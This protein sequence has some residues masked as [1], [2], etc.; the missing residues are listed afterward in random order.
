MELLFIDSF[1]IN[2]FIIF[3]DFIGN[4]SASRQPCLIARECIV[5]IYCSV[6]PLVIK[7]HLWYLE[8]PSTQQLV[9]NH[10]NNPFIDGITTEWGLTFTRFTNQLQMPRSR[11]IR[12]YSE[13][14]FAPFFV[15]GKPRMW[16]L[17]EVPM[18]NST[19]IKMFMLR[20][21]M[22]RVETTNQFM[23]VMSLG[24]VEMMI[25]YMG[26]WGNYVTNLDNFSQNL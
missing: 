13:W 1:P 3:H 4:F 23:F 5:T 10:S 22:I 26:F 8:D 12:N 14:M 16:Q 9:S 6:Y 24:H 15:V 20:G 21:N 25:S 18:G 2:N 11:P 17:C 7:T 19:P